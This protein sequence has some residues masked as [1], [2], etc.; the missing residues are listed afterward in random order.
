MSKTSRTSKTSKT[1][2]FT[3]LHHLDVIQGVSGLVRDFEP[4]VKLE[5]VQQLGEQLALLVEGQ[6]QGREGTADQQFAAKK[7]IY[8]FKISEG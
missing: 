4:G 5:L 2:K 3:N 6:V 1:F 7:E 8:F